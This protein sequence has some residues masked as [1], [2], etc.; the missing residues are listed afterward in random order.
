MLLSN[1]N[2]LVATAP[3]WAKHPGEKGSHTD[4]LDELGFLAICPKEGKG[5]A[6]ILPRCDTE[7]MNLHL[8]EIATAIAPGNHAVLLVDQ[9]G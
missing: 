8:A 5:A 3:A 9:A 6:L 7:T 1:A 2:A 4:G